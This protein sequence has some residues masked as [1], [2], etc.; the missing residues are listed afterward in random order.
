MNVV[1]PGTE[2]STASIE[3]VFDRDETTAATAVT[4]EPIS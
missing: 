1:V 4:T 2:Q 3:A